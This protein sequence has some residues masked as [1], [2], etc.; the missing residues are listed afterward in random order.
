M[1]RHSLRFRLY[2][3]AAATVV[4]ALAVAAFGLVALFERHAERRLDA[5]MESHLRQL[6]GRLELGPGGRVRVTSDPAD[7][8]F[9]A[10]LSGLYWQLGD[11]TRPALLRS[12]SLW[13]QTIPL[14][15]DDLSL[16]VVHRHRLPGPAGQRLLVRERQVILRPDSDARRLRVAVAVD[17]AELDAA[18]R[19]FAADI[20]PFLGLL[21]A[22]FFAA[23]WVQV[24]TGLAPLDLVRRRVLAVRAGA[25]RRLEDHFPDEV[26]PL[27]EEINELLAARDQA[28]ERA[29]AWTG[30]LAHGLKTPLTA[31]GADARRLRA[32]GHEDM[33][34]HLEELAQAM[35]Q[36]VDRELIRA[37]LRSAA[38]G[39]R[40]RA[41]L[42][43]GVERVL[44][45][46]RRTPAG[47][48]L[49]WEADLP[50]AAPARIQDDD[51]NE[52]L[53][54]LLEN[55]A[56][57]AA[58]RVRVTVAPGE[59]VE[60]TVADDGPGVA[61]GELPRLGQRG[62]RLDEQTP[63]TGL[64]LA[65]VGDIVEAYG[66]DLGFFPADLGGLGVRVRLPPAAGAEK[67]GRRD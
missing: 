60:L 36:R 40:E 38:P 17:R 14:P 7:P 22:L 63:G 46:L 27:V 57:W 1:T 66:G 30:D 50:A 8:R 37:R 35:R 47:E 44:A 51:L 48:A 26:T 39:A 13:D 65:I 34:A 64:G 15:A 16:G 4:T 42:V 32:L 6:I 5:E 55:A 29:R 67:R 61:P 59:G 25:A 43:Q 41:D 3:A 62:V 20:L 33:A 19:A 12:R 11:V 23:T 45:T 54:N 52:L 56:K 58:A 10:P 2:S 18:G 53:G 21:A 49:S 31:L 28:V 24:R 9:Q